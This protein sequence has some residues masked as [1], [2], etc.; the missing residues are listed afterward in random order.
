MNILE[1]LC[2]FAVSSSNLKWKALQKQKNNEKM[3]FNKAKVSIDAETESPQV[4]MKPWLH[5]GQGLLR[6]LLRAS[7]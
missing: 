1:C 5:L 2:G 4:L 7:K 6:R 3:S